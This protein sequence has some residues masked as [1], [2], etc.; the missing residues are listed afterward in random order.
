MTEL[1][2]MPHIERAAKG[3][4]P[5]DEAELAAA[6]FLACY[7]ARTL[8]AYR[9][10]LRAFFQRTSGQVVA[11]VQLYEDQLPSG[12]SVTYFVDEQVPYVGVVRIRRR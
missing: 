12:I 9:Y 2:P 3:D 11:G 10:D 5:V 7:Q 4:D 8:E 6:A 1:M